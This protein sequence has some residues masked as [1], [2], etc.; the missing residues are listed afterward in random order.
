VQTAHGKLL[1]WP[2]YVAGQTEY[3]SDV[4]R[5]WVINRMEK[6]ADV[7]IGKATV[8]ARMLKAGIYTPKVS[9]EQVPEEAWYNKKFSGD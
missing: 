9:R 6:L 2:L 5:S 7:G 3:V 4:M 1:L 8:L